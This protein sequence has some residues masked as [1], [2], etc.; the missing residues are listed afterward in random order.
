MMDSW[1]TVFCKVRGEAAAEFNL[2]KQGYAVY[3]PRLVS[4]RRRAGKWVECVEPLFPRYLFLKHRDSRQSLAPVRSTIGVAHLVRFGTRFA[5]MS[6]ALIEQLQLREAAMAETQDARPL[7]EPG[8]AVKFV[9]GPF[10]GVEAVFS[11]T[12]GSDRVIVLL[13]LLGKLNS[14]RVDP[15]CLAPAA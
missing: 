9:Q 2:G 12:V 3:L 14:L 1:Y 4:R 13:D 10:S 6:D 7:F 15:A 11:K 8:M 5:L